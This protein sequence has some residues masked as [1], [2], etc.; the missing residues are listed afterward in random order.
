LDEAAGTVWSQQGQGCFASDGRFYS[1]IGDHR[2]IDGR[3]SLY[4]LDLGALRLS[5]IIDVRE[6]LGQRPGD[7]GH[8]VVH[9][10]LGEY[11][12]AV[13][14]ATHWNHPPIEEQLNERYEGGAIVRYDLRQQKATSLGA[15]LRG[16][17]YPAYVVDERR[18]RL[19]AATTNGSV[20]GYDLKTRTVLS[21]L[22]AGVAVG[23][24]GLICD[25]ETGLVYFTGK[26]DGSEDLWLYAIEPESKRMEATRAA[27]PRGAGPLRAAT[28]RK[29]SDGWFCC[30]TFDGTLFR[31][32]PATE[33]IEPLPHGPGLHTTAL[34]LSPD[35]HFLYWVGGGAQGTAWKAGCPVVQ[36]DLRTRKPKVIA[37]LGP[38]YERDYGYLLGGA[39]GVAI[40]S[41]GRKLILEMN[42]SVVA[43]DPRRTGFGVPSL[44]IIELPEKELK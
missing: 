7:F 31:F 10:R 43:K 14:F 41:S 35:E 27:L 42:G 18:G 38:H 5:K 9:G 37:F 2:S 34:A 20:L 6:L 28:D 19:Y 4:A 39:Y 30:L 25:E 3:V 16:A 24:R 22:G 40:D 17:S 29:S 15:P 26:K 36:Y 23:H 44:A 32:H 13:Y 11:D 12:G 21:D 8:G 33:A 1:V